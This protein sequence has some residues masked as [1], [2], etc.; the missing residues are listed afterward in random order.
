[1]MD[2]DEQQMDVF[3]DRLRLL[4]IDPSCNMRRFYRMTV[5]RDLFG[6]ASLVRE[7]GR[8][9]TSGQSLT[10]SHE[11]EGQAINALMKR[12]RAKQNKGYVR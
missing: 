1:M 3:P 5:L 8:I 11:D 6:R 2:Q 7:W 12:A 10:E 4:R 9:G